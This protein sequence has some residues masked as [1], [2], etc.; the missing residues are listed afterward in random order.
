M[1]LRGFGTPLCTDH[2]SFYHPGFEP[3][4][5]CPLFDP[6]AANK[7]LEDNGWAKGP[8]G[9]RTKRA[10]FSFRLALAHFPVCCQLPRLQR[11]VAPL[12]PLSRCF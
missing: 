8:D 3:F 5:P 11:E 1:A 6:A 7:L 2:G 12:L 9:V 4:A 10:F